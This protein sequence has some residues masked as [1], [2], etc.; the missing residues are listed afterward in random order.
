[1]PVILTSKEQWDMWM[2]APWDEAS[3]L[4]RPLDDTAMIEV[5]R[6]ADKEDY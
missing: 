6:G 1:M 2:R 5:K 3:Q 4:Q